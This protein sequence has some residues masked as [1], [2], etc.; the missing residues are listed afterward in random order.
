[1][2]LPTLQN[3]LGEDR[4]RLCIMDEGGATGAGFYVLK[5]RDGLILKREKKLVSL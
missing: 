4:L 3:N 1:M 5:Q 2:D